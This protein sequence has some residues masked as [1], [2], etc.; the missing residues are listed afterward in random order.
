MGGNVMQ[1]SRSVGALALITIV[2]LLLAACSSS[3]TRTST[4]PADTPGPQVGMELTPTPTSERPVATPTPTLT[5]TP[6]PPGEPLPRLILP[7][8]ATVVERVRDSVV[9]VVAEIPNSGLFGG[10]SSFQSGSGV[11]FDDQ[12]HILT[13]NHVIEGAISV[14]VTLDDGRQLDATIRGTDLLTD[15]AVLEVEVSSLPHVPFAD[16]SSVRVGDW[17]IAIGNAL[18]LPGGPSVTL[19]IVSA[20]NRTFQID[21]NVTLYDLVQ[22]DTII[23]PG[24]SGG[25]LL[26]LAGEVVG[27]NTA[28]VRGG[29]VEGI[30][31]AIGGETAIHVSRELIESGRVRWPW[32][33]VIISDLDAEQAAELG[34][35]AGQGILIQDALRDGPADRGGLERGDV[36]LSIEGNGTPQIRDLTL[37]LR[38]SFRIGDVVDVEVL[39]DGEMKTFQVNLGER[40]TV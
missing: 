20:L 32:L 10:G 40:P 25:P 29:R 8:V 16:P 36:M 4:P 34:L 19:G 30:G 3:A 23:N 27:I 14:V 22:T 6:R 13:N 2:I 18:A 28:V 9:S 38:F 35:A 11:I 12:G 24:N 37:L 1:R 5:P 39:R 33:G 31:F 15:M 26:N 7:D 21:Q 17:V